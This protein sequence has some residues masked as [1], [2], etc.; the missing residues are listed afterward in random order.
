MIGYFF[1]AHITGIDLEGNLVYDRE[2]LAAEH[3]NFYDAFWSTGLFTSADADA[4]KVTAVGGVLTVAPGRVFINGYQGI[5]EGDDT[6]DVSAVASG[7][8]RV[9]VRLD[10]SEDVRAFSCFLAEGS[11]SSYPALVRSGNV[12]DLSLANVQV[13]TGVPTIVDTR[14]DPA[15]CGSSQVSGQASASPTRI[16]GGSANAY[17]LT[18]PGISSLDELVGKK[19]FVQFHAANTSTTVNIDVNGFGNR[20][21]YVIGTTVPPI[22]RLAIDSQWIIEYDGTAFVMWG[23]AN[24]EPP[25][26]GVAFATCETA[27]GTAAKVATIAG[28]TRSAGAIACVRFSTSNT[29]TTPTLNVN[30]TGAAQIRYNGATIIGTRLTAGDH[31]FQFDGTYWNWLNYGLLSQVSA[32]GVKRLIATFTTSGTFTRANYTK[33]DGTPLTATDTI[34]VYMVGG[35][36]GGAGAI[37]ANSSNVRPGGGGGG[38]GY[39]V[40]IRDY[41][42]SAASYAITVG[43]G[44]TR[45]VG[46]ASGGSNTGTAGGAGGSTTGFG[47]TASGGAG[48]DSSGGINSNYARGGAGGSGGGCSRTTSGSAGGYAGGNA[49]SSGLDTTYG[50]VGAGTQFSTTLVGAITTNTLPI[51]I[52]PFT[53]ALSGGGGGGG[54]VYGVT[55]DNSGGKYNNIGGGN[56][57]TSPGGSGADA[58]TNSGGGGGGGSAG[59]STTSTYAAGGNGGYGAAGIVLIYA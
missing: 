24:T 1:D 26:N 42:V 36:G 55:M 48:G 40:A 12:Y 13:T 4:C 56:G 10:I 14:S 45:G 28:F 41:T 32:I 23:V 35:G 54:S 31:V 19:L 50:G 18:M 17:T 5:T 49:G 47:A 22:G 11:G 21:L 59:Y 7:Y 25:Q 34:D 27:A 20:R 38:S 46:G 39:A 53:G 51:P 37:S 3:A 30:G 6:F 44:G 57:A 8:F 15:L 29:A 9:I 16:M 43:S 52:N 58:S 33:A 2:Y